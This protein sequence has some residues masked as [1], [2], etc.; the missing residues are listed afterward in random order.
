MGRWD[1]HGSSASPT[2]ETNE[3]KLRDHTTRAYIRMRLGRHICLIRFILLPKGSEEL[4]AFKR[5]LPCAILR[6]DVAGIED[7]L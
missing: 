5:L 6:E 7:T 4:C 1:I 2:T 3:M